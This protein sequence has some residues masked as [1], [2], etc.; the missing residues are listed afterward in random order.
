VVSPELL[1]ILDGASEPV[2]EGRPTS[3]ERARTPCL[4]ELAREGVLTRLRTVPAGLEPGSEV[5]IPVL[6][7]SVPDRAVDR[8]AIEA[9]AREIAVGPGERA[10]RVD[11]MTADGG[12][13]DEP[14]TADAARRLRAGAPAHAMHLLAG[15]RLLLV[16]PGPLPDAARAPGLRPWP[17]GAALPPADGPPTVVIAAVGAAAGIGR[18]MGARVVVPPG[19]TGGPVSDL[20][21]KAAAALRAL[22]GGARRVVVHVA[23]PDE[24]AHL[25]D[26]H[27]KVAALERAD[28]DLVGPLTAALRATGGSL[29]VCPDHGCDPATGR[30]DAQPV[31]CV[32]WPGPGP[33]GAPLPAGRRRL[34]ERAVAE[35]A[36]TDLPGAPVAA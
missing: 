18:L 16:G 35:L 15:H 20:A 24:A 8:G 10:W 9:A 33:E 25:L 5:A 14:A 36:V 2:R 6:L 7:G 19:A 27:G 4:D 23:G 11:A 12:R 26:A 22:A 28:R 3:L 1:V 31:P 32:T 13:A 34:T 29:R 30:H 17:Q 21:A